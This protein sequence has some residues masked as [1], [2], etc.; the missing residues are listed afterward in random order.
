MDTDFIRVACAVIVH[1][2]LI[3]AVQRSASMS[4]P[5]LWEFPGGKIETGESAAA[6]V[7]REVEEE[8]GLVIEPLAPLTPTK[9]DYGIVRIE[10]VPFRAHVVSG[11][12]HLRE[13]SACRWL[14]A[15]ELLTLSWAAADL[16]VVFEVM[17]L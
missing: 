10:L 3:L 1:N 13:H 7:V 11:M 6:C 16:P 17:G 12:L 4:H 9:H 15:E 8:L 2:D 5:L 14:P